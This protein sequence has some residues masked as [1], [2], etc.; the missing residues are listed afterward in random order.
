MNHNSDNSVQAFY[1]AENSSRSGTHVAVTAE[2]IEFRRRSANSSIV[3]TRLTTC[4]RT[5]LFI[6]PRT[7]SPA[8]V[9]TPSTSFI[10]HLGRVHQGELDFRLARSSRYDPR[11]S[12]FED[13]ANFRRDPRAYI[14]VP[15]MTRSTHIIDISYY[16]HFSC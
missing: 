7:R 10:S 13:S 16:E 6:S 8:I 1:E 5:S 2:F 15:S 3:I 14:Q 9:D 12:R 11:A 4:G